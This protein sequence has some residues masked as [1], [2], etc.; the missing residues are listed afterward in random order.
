MDEHHYTDVLGH[1]RHNSIIIQGHHIL[2]KKQVAIKIIRKQ[3]KSRQDLED[4]RQQV[5]LYHLATHTYVIE[6]ED[7]FE[8]PDCFYIVYELHN[9][10]TLKNYLKSV[11]DYITE[12]DLRD[13]ALKIAQTIDFLHET[14]IMIK[15]LSIDSFLMSATTKEGVID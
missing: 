8:T 12:E 14:G 7:F 9:V 6:L 13:F 3:G 2:T 5:D 4:I 11:N 10:L 15:N 1:G